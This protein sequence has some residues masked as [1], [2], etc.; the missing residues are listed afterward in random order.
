ML[1]ISGAERKTGAR[2]LAPALRQELR[3]RLNASTLTRLSRQLDLSPEAVLRALGGMGV[4]SGTLALLERALA[5]PRA[6]DAGSDG[7]VSQSR[8]KGASK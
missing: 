4:R 3:R 8:S 2:P 7:Q 5:A 1:M 6:A